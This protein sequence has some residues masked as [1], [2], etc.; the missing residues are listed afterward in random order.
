MIQ[1][2]NS[3]NIVAKVLKIVRYSARRGGRVVQPADQC[4]KQ[5]FDPAHLNFA[6]CLAVGEVRKVIDLTQ[7][8]WQAT[9]DFCG[10]WQVLATWIG[11]ELGTIYVIKVEVKKLIHANRTTSVYEV[12]S[13]GTV[14]VEQLFSCKSIAAIVTTAYPSPKVFTHISK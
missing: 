5:T 13:W 4:A 9:S 2:C 6:R 3:N 11:K 1:R 8:L 7:Y 14:R 12:R 10:H